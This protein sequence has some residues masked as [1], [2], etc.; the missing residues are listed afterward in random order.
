MSTTLTRTAARLLA[1]PL[2]A[3]L[4]TVAPITPAPVAHA[5]EAFDTA[6]G[7]ATSDRNRDELAQV[8]RENR[9]TVGERALRAAKTRAGMAYRYGATGPSA[10]DCSGLTQWAYGKAGRRLPR[11]SGAQAGA[12]RRVARPRLGDLVFFT[13][14]GSVYHVGLYAGNHTVFHASRSGVPVRKERIWTSS[15]FYGRVG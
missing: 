13:S 8:R 12:V 5:Q 15:V 10:F 2:A 3:T 7:V 6:P 14:G 11:T 1:L 9:L 4:V